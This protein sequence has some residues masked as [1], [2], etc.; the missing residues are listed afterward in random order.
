L[1]S[2]RSE[3]LSFDMPIVVACVETEDR[4]TAI[5]PE[6]DTMIDGGLIVYRPR[7]P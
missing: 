1:Q 5:L 7:S 3:Y 6:L 2:G 4:I